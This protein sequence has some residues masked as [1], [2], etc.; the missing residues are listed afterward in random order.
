MQLRSG[1][2]YQNEMYSNITIRKNKIRRRYNGFRNTCQGYIGELNDATCDIQRIHLVYK[3]YSFIYDDKDNLLEYINMYESLVNF[4]QQVADDTPRFIRD[5]ININ[6]DPEI[7]WSDMTGL[8]V[9]QDA[10]IFYELRQF[11]LMIIE[12]HN[13]NH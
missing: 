1:S 9:M 5:I 7:S 4:L 12:C 6:R 10:Y 11:L 2:R 8:T 13:E 3:L